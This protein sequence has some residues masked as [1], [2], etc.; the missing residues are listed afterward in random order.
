MSQ[1]DILFVE[2]L[3]RQLCQ[4]KDNVLDEAI[5]SKDHRIRAAAMLSHAAQGELYALELAKHVGSADTMLERQAARKALVLISVK[6]LGRGKGY[7]DFG[8][9]P[10]ATLEQCEASAKLWRAWYIDE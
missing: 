10:N 8:P 7:R 9:L 2:Q 6:K 1:E 5:Q 3:A 4:C